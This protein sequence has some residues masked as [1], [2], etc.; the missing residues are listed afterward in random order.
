MDSSTTFKDAVRQMGGVTVPWER[1]V[2]HWIA[3]RLPA[4]INSDHLTLLALLA[5]AL[6]GAGYWLSATWVSALWLVN[7]GLIINW[8]GDSLD[9]TL[10][11]IRQ[12]QRPRYGFYVDHVVDAAGLTMLLG[13]M[14]L[15]GYLTPLIAFGLLAAYLLVCVEVYLATY[16]VGTFRMSFFKIGP[17]E[18]RILLAAGNIATLLWH[19][20]PHVTV[21]GVPARLFDVAALLATMGL[22]V[23]FVGSAVNNTRTLYRAEPLPK[24]AD[25]QFSAVPAR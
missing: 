1:R 8:F 21:L 2:L 25:D 17:T 24:A 5:M 22:V 11:R 7:I 20:D 19:P 13:G 12:H 6:A 18:L 23:A 14:A 16:C 9:G 3:P 15:S 4:A 10:A